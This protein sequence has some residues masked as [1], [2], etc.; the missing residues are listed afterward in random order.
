MRRVRPRNGRN[1]L[2]RRPTWAGGGEE[3]SRVGSHVEAVLMDAT[4]R[5]VDDLRRPAM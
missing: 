1:R 3:I 5:F 4:A 2:Q